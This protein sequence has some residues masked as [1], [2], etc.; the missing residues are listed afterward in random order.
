[1]VIALVEQQVE[2]SHQHEGNRNL[3]KQR[4]IT[5]Q[6]NA[7][8]RYSKHQQHVP[9]GAHESCQRKAENADELTQIRHYQ[10]RP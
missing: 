7:A 4:P 3:D 2:Q 6:A 10:H 5:L 9:R 1:M 8:A